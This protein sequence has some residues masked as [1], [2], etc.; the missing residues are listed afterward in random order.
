MDDIKFDPRKEK[1]YNSDNNA[2]ASDPNVISID[3]R[4]QKPIHD[5]KCVHDFFHDTLDD[6]NSWAKVMKCRNCPA[7]YLERL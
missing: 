4:K 3:M 5:P 1:S 7:G 6:D 2:N